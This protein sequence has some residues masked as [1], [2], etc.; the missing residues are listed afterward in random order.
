MLVEVK[1]VSTNSTLVNAKVMSLLSYK[2]SN[3]SQSYQSKKLL[4]PSNKQTEALEQ[5]L[6]IYQ[7]KERSSLN[8]IKDLLGQIKSNKKISK[9]KKLKIPSNLGNLGITPILSRE[10][11]ISNLTNK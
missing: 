2:L 4:K 7:K 9:T 11:L 10:Q 3:I 5:F 8:P 6:S 1:L